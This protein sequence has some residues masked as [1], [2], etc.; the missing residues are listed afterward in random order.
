MKRIILLC[1]GTWQDSLAQTHWYPS[2]VSRMARAIKPV[3]SDGIA[4]VVYYHP[5]VGSD[6]GI[7]GWFLGGTF[8]EGIVQQMKDVYGFLSYNYVPGDEIFFFGFSR[9]SY[10][11]RALCSLVMEFGILQK[12]GMSEFVEVF[13]LF[14]KKKFEKNV[15][16]QKLQADLA[17]REALILPANEKHKI[18]VKAI[19]CFDT[20]GSLGVPRIFPWQKND[21]KFLDLKLNPNVEHAFHA[22][23]LDEPRIVFQPTLWFFDPRGPNFDNYKQVWFTGNHENIGG[24]P[25]YGTA[26]GTNLLPPSKKVKIPNYWSDG[27]LAWLLSKFVAQVPNVLSDGTLIWMVSQCSDL[28]DFDDKYLHVDIHGGHTKRDGELDYKAFDTHAHKQEPVWYR[29]PI[30]YN[31]FFILL[32]AI[33]W[34]PWPPRDVGGYFPWEKDYEWFLVRWLKWLK[35]LVFENPEQQELV[36]KERVHISVYNRDL[37]TGTKSAALRNV[38]LDPPNESENG[39]VVFEKVKNGTQHL[40]VA[41]GASKKKKHV[42]LEHYSPFEEAFWRSEKQDIHDTNKWKK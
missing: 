39:D 40:D 14:M 12:S 31:I 6:G 2:N 3:D 9:G 32:G 1:D 23:A 10:M 5:G 7:L 24:G 19:G 17:K 35:H 30:N 8:G 28:L 20:V 38:I 29:G 33:P 18:T 26:P 37:I 42:P 36:T 15:A 13:Q 25:M 34:W 41:Q 11:V 22:L 21:Y 16:L 27:A 4:Q